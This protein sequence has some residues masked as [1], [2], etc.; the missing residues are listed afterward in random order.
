M[1]NFA[2]RHL[3]AIQAPPGLT[4]LGHSQS[5]PSGLVSVSLYTQ[6]DVLGYSQPELSRIANVPRLVCR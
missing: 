1:L 3:R 4:V 6:D 5:F 2:C